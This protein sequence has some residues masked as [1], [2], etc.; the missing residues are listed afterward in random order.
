MSAP[1]FVTPTHPAT[2]ELGRGTHLV[3]MHQH[4]DHQRKSTIAA[5]PPLPL[6]RLV[7]LNPAPS[8]VPSLIFFVV[9]SQ[10]PGSWLFSKH[11]LASWFPH[12]GGPSRP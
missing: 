5:T 2:T 3:L 12:V 11:T 10:W 1:P 8:S 6:Q 7:R 4:C 9:D